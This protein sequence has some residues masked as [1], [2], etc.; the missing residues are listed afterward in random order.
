MPTNSKRSYGIFANQP[1]SADDVKS[2]TVSDITPLM[3]PG[4]V[5]DQRSTFK[6]LTTADVRARNLHIQAERRTRPLLPTNDASNTLTWC[7]VN[8]SLNYCNSML[9]GAPA[10]TISWLCRVQINA[11]RVV[12]K[13][14]G[15][16]AGAMPEL[17][18]LHSLPVYW[19][20]SY[21]LALLLDL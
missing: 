21:K 3:S 16:R 9:Y 11:A 14:S 19:H 2:L 15:R 7:L 10:A 18:S 13:M 1:R 17:K 8:T 6:S 20:I 4:A 5:L 12:T